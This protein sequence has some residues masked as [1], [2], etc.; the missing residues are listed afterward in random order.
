MEVSI[1]VYFVIHFQ[2]F[3]K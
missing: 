2:S 1:L 3:I